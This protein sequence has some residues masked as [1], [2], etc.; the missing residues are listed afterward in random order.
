[1]QPCSTLSGDGHI[2]IGANQLKPLELKSDVD[3]ALADIVG[4]LA[5]FRPDSKVVIFEGGGDADFDRWMTMSLFPELAG[6]YNLISGSNKNKVKALH[7]VLN[8]A[9]EKGNIS[10]K[11]FAIVDSDYDSD[12]DETSA[13]SRFS[14][15]VYH[16]ENFLLDTDIISKVISPLFKTSVLKE[17][18]LDSLKSCARSTVPKAI[19]H[20]ITEY[21]SKHF[22]RAI[23]LGF[24]PSADDVGSAI[25]EAVGRS[26]ERAKLLQCEALSLENLQEVAQTARSKIEASF[27]DGSWRSTLPGRDILRA[28]ANT[29]PN[30][31]SHETLRTMIVNKMVDLGVKPLGMAKVLDEIKALK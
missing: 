10:T 24:D 13:V 17:E 29:L 27:A 8:N 5:A 1:M 14:W 20:K 3:Q 12:R 22:M 30:G 16:I 9:F 18:I 11:F 31:I 21:S 4:D 26:V 28:Y 23:D 2:T 25:H 19:R 7:E 6:K 15:P